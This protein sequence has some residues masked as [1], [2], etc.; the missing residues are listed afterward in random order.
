MRHQTKKNTLGKAQDQRKALL[1]SL[2][3]EL[4]TYGDLKSFVNNLFPSVRSLVIPPPF[5]TVT[6]V[7]LSIVLNLVKDCLNGKLE[8]QD[9]N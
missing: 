6:G 1:R 9:R 3:T 8:S 2:A 7:A 5:F 4:F